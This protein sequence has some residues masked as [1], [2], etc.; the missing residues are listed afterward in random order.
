MN[1]ESAREIIKG[2]KVPFRCPYCLIFKR[3]SNEFI[4]H[5][6]AFH[7]LELKKTFDKLYVPEDEMIIINMN[8]ND[9]FEIPSNSVPPVQQS[10]SSSNFSNERFDISN[11]VFPVPS[12]SVPPVQQSVSSS[13]MI[14]ITNERIKNNVDTSNDTMEITSNSN[15]PTSTVLYNIL[16][17]TP[18]KNVPV[19]TDEELNLGYQMS[20]PKYCRI[21]KKGFASQCYIHKHLNVEHQ[22]SNLAVIEANIIERAKKTY[23]KLKTP[24]SCKICDK[25]FLHASGLYKHLR[26]KHDLSAIKNIKAYVNLV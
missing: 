5:I 18:V 9:V 25:W 24:L 15:Q 16:K 7:F 22:I 14:E 10:V 8:P 6:A 23:K 11:K 3:E 20:Y 26:S 21:C 4:E 19:I 13:S 2:I 1:I 12:N 17:N